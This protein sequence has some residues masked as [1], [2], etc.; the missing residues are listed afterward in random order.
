VPENQEGRPL[1]FSLTLTELAFM[2]FFL[3]LLLAVAQLGVQ[4]RE[5]RTRSEDATVV[6]ALGELQ[7][8]DVVRRRILEDDRDFFELVRAPLEAI[9]RSPEPERLKRLTALIEASEMEGRGEESCAD[10]VLD[11]ERTNVNLRGQL[12]HMRQR[13]GRGGIDYP[14]CWADP[15][16]GTIVYI[17]DITIHEET[18]DVVRAWPDWR[19]PEVRAIP[20]AA[21]LLGRGY[22][23][24]AFSER[25]WP[26]LAW[27]NAES[28]R[29]YVRIYDEAETK[30]GFKRTLLTVE[31]FFYKYLV[32]E[33]VR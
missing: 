33:P 1:L 5:L 17:Y 19:D 15:T 32:L 26:I 30:D 3:L 23:I 13:C 6:T 27:S 11:L 8:F 2:M 29:H 24:R 7:G 25:A 16:T 31:Q 12:E 18:I 21:E 4:S 20:G 9:L 22:S 28:C 14:P 10:R